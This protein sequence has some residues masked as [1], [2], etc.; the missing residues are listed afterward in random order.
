MARGRLD[1][2][3]EGSA[4]RHGETRTPRGLDLVAEA[5]TGPGVLGSNG[6]G[7][8]AGAWGS[9]WSARRSRSRATGGRWPAETGHTDFPEEGTWQSS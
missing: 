3:A 8:A 1:I 5:A 9:L 6:A 4:K 7:K 2:L